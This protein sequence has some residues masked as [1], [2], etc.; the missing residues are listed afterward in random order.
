MKLS[1]VP[2]E[3][4][5]EPVY[6]QL[7][8][9]IAAAIDSGSLAVESPLPSSRDLAAELGLSRDTVVNA[10]RELK[11]L[12]YV[13]GDKTRGTY[14]LPGPGRQ[15]A[16]SQVLPSENLDQSKLSAFGRLIVAA[17]FDNPSSSSFSALNH[18]AVPRSALPIRRWRTLMQQMCEPEYFK[19]LEYTPNVLG[20]TELRKAIAA[21]LARSKGLGCDW[22]QVAVFSVSSGLI[23][24]LCKILLDPGSVVAVEEPGYGAI[25]NLARSQGLTLL[26]IPVDENGMDVAALKSYKGRVKMVY[27]TPGRHDPTG[28][29]MS[30]ARRLDLLSW[31]EENDVWIVEDDY[32]GNFYYGAERPAPLWTVAPNKNVIYSG[33]FWQVL[34]PLTT[35]GFAVIPAA[36]VSAV[37]AGK[38][39][40]T[41]GISDFMRQLVLAQ[42]LDQGYLERH[43]RK[44]AKTFAA[45]RAALIYALKKTLG[46]KITIS[47]Y[48]AGNYFVVL[49]PDFARAAVEK[50][51]ETAALPLQ[52]TASYYLGK[53]RS[54]EYLINFA[55]V[56]EAEAGERAQK[57]VDCLRAR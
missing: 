1:F 11:R 23:S 19:T 50:A 55:L 40:Q 14:V 35:V 7:A 49:L 53:S 20:R 47:N 41:E 38:E 18:G 48:S 37:S 9:V 17:A 32:D 52:A 54:G 22:R 5:Q 24:V 44:V 21:Y 26:P 13:G 56:P 43:L 16:D 15:G 27:V 45:R 3:N 29:I 31:A 39:L 6:A 2:D 36:L 8:A 30:A 25:K 28:V 10:Y 34:Y 46:K 12:A 33:S 42:M 57:F 51:A 4:S